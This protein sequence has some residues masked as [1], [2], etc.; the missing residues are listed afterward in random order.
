[1]RG[2][3]LSVQGRLNVVKTD[4]NQSEGLELAVRQLGGAIGMRYRD[5]SCVMDADE[6]VSLLETTHALF[7]ERRDFL[8]QEGH[9]SWHFRA[10]PRD[11]I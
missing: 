4:W 2:P 9:S 11:Q 10:V 1:M 5:S 7:R 6:K 8:T 3:L